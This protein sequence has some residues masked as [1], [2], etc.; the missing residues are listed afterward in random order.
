MTLFWVIIYLGI[1][2]FLGYL[3]YKKTSGA[4]DYLVAG[5]QIHPY[6]MA[7]SYGATFISTSAIVGFGGAAAVFGMGM[8][9]LTVLNIFVGIFIAFVFF[10][11][12]TRTMGFHLDAHTF[13]EFLGKRY[14]S[15]FIQKFAGIVIFLFMP[16]YAGVVLMGAA[17]FIEQQLSISYTT[18]LLFFTLI[19]ALYVI[20]G[21]LK[22]VM[23]TDAFQG[24]IMFIGMAILIVY[25][26][27]ILGGVI[28]AHQALTDMPVPPPLAAK[29]HNGW[30]SMPTFNSSYWWVMVTTLVMGVGIGVL[31]QPQL[32]VR[33]MT[34]KSN[35][36]LNRA[37]LV[38]GIFI[39]MMTGVAFTTGALSNVFFSKNINNISFSE[40]TGMLMEIVPGVT[41]TEENIDKFKVK[42]KGIAPGDKIDTEK[43]EVQKAGKKGT[44]AIKAVGGNVENIIPQYIKQAMPHWFSILFM[45]T[46][47]A[48]A[49]ST[50]SSQFHAMGT[51]I[52]RDVYEQTVK[53][54]TRSNEWSVYIS[55][56]GIA[57][58]IIISALL[59]Y[60]LPKFF[61]DAGI[62]I[63]ARG[64]A[65]FFGLCA[66]SFL[67][68][69]MGA[70]YFKAITRSAAI[71][72]M[73][74]GFIV[75]ALWITFIHDKEAKA[76]GICNAL[77]G[78]PYLFDNTLAVVDPMLIAL[79]I[80]IALTII[81]SLFT[82][83][84]DETH[85]SM[86]FKD[87]A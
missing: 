63:I 50:L 3:G 21:G 31:A 48:A 41:V 24:T 65:I 16:L 10:G 22:G 13:P 27:H 7:L 11:K 56:I 76:L 44:I 15:P 18:A 59:A 6:I 33:F 73:L 37:I 61:G 74:G 32:V 68:A 60:I 78:K 2:A 38:G 4:S 54:V 62:A 45:L 36:E 79:P 69:Y 8:L 53:N 86:C 58:T 35:R 83:K 52:G 64:T 34:V 29:G 9:W 57:F 28:D 40:S 70:L 71:T 17:A 26:Y 81:V 75:S 47:L 49:M 25:T 67:P 19:V 85:V 30:T 46:L 14:Q 39:L 66:G 72:G 82:K 23:Y 43:E 12:R 80:S 87:I 55:K 42:Y 51:A 1:I 84:F 20:M 77:F 5:R